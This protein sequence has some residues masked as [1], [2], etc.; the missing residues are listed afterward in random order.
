M[1][2]APNISLIVILYMTVQYLALPIATA[3]YSVPQDFT[4]IRIGIEGITSFAF[5]VFLIKR[6]YRQESGDVKKMALERE[7]YAPHLY[8]LSGSLLLVFG[9]IVKLKSC[10]FYAECSDYFYRLL[11]PN[12]LYLGAFITVSFGLLLDISQDISTRFKN[13]ILLALLF[14]VLNIWLVLSGVGR[15]MGAYY[16][17]SILLLI[18]YFNFKLSK[19]K[20]IIYSILLLSITWVV[21]SAGKNIVVDNLPIENAISYNFVA[22][23]IIF[24][25]SQAHI[26]ESIYQNW[27]NNLYLG[28][29][30]WSDLFSIPGLGIKRNYL[31]GNDFGYAMHLI[32]DHDLITG[33]GP[34]F[35]GDL[36]IRGGEYLGVIL[37][38]FFLGVVFGFYQ[39]FLGRLNSNLAV[40]IMVNSFPF[41]LHGTED[42]IFLT[43]STFITI[44][45][46]YLIFFL[47]IE[48]IYSYLSKRI[49][50]Q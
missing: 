48:K 19:I 40:I 1:R 25:I 41:F 10:I 20:F 7:C 34:T 30:G 39:I 46:F 5:G 27:P 9:A 26:L 6:G 32:G 33:V 37:G 29:Y 49:V 50:K 28:A 17:L 4:L 11:H 2:T 21:I 14:F 43:L 36:Y 8:Y 42:F 13:V 44:N 38:M 24:R 16:A 23:K 31:N 22:S 3:F 15:S 45:L 12:L 35:I 18:C 47:V